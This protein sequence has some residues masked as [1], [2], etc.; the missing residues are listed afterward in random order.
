MYV[1]WDQ[2]DIS[3]MVTPI[4]VKFCTMVHMGLV[5]WFSSFGGQYPQGIS[6]I[7]NFGPLKSEYLKNC[8]LQQ[9]EHKSVRRKLFKNV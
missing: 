1:F 4:S 2:T 5:R 9:L 8:K 6:K 3:A 7:Q